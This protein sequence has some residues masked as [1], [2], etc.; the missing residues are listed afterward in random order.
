MTI[1][2][3][4]DACPICATKHLPDEPHNQQSLYYQQRFHAVRGR[5]PTWADAI[6]HCT[7]GVRRHW[8]TELRKLGHRSE[9]AGDT[10]SPSA[11]GTRRVIADPPAEW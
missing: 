4:A 7:P 9:P 10:H 3:A 1:P 11:D 2:P 5:W 8:E 6:A